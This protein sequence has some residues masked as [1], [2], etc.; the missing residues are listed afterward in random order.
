MSPLRFDRMPMLR[1][2]LSPIFAASLCVA[3]L[4]QDPFGG[5]DPF[6]GGASP[7]GDDEPAATATAPKQEEEDESPLKAQLLEHA[8]RGF[9]QRAVAIA[10]LVRTGR[11]EDADQLLTALA[12]QNP[13]AATLAAMSRE[14]GPALFLRMKTSDRISDAAKG[15]LDRM[16]AAAIAEA[17][18]VDRL[19]QAIDGLDAASVDTRLASSRTLIA[20]GNAAVAELVAAAVSPKPLSSREIILR[21]MLEFDDAGI[22][23]LQQLAL[24]GNPD[25]RVRAMQALSRIDRRGHVPE[26]LTA[27]HA[28]DS[29]EAEKDAARRQLMYLDS[30]IPS[31]GQA[32]VRLENEFRQRQIDAK[33]VDNDEQTVTVWLVG[34][35]GKSVQPQ[36]TTA[37]LA[38]YRDVADAGVRLRRVG[39]LS[40]QLTGAVLSADMAYRLM[41]DPD[42]GDPE[43]IEQIRAAYG[44]AS[45]PEALSAAI[46]RS[47]ESA[48]HAA[49]IGLLRLVDPANATEM[50][51]VILLNGGGTRATP[52]VQAASSSNPQVRYEAALTASKLAGG[53]PY[54]GSSVVR[55]TLTE[56]SRLG[57]RPTAILVETLPAVV[58]R[59]ETILRN[60]GY[61]TVVVRNVHQLQRAIERGGDLRLILSKIELSDFSPIEMVDLV[62]RAPRGRDLPIVFYGPED[63]ALMWKRWDAPTILMNMPS[64]A[65]ALDEVLDMVQRR[66]RIPPLSVIDRQRYRGEAAPTPAS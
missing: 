8:R 5:P 4:A 11:Y 58:I 17:E 31:A 15:M 13:D 57:D 45:G 20:G 51:R 52:L 66:R 18:S 14:I 55:K 39:G 64:S 38:A 47:L 27:L 61:E 65:A 23:A 7:F 29:T 49:T 41:V 1:L 12:N 43:Q 48:N 32:L 40:E 42:W 10:S 37:M 6:G 63:P 21:A 62:R 53:H 25:V 35:D 26:L 19:R 30:P 28:S 33:R 9:L 36:T 56:M 44:S 2:C 59:L 34:E 3:V 54:A 16:G 22:R 60:L 46:D 50:D 24:Y